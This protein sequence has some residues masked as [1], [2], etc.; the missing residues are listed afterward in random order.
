MNADGLANPSG[1]SLLVISARPT[2]ASA[3]VADGLSS[4]TET[5]NS[6]SMLSAAVTLTRG[7][8]SS[9]VST[10]A[11]DLPAGTAVSATAPASTRIVSPSASTFGAAAPLGSSSRQNCRLAGGSE[12]GTIPNRHTVP[13]PGLSPVVS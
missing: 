4:V 6:K 10:A 1:L 12:T 8:L 13:P 3:G 9:T 2:C 5:V 7:G 11:S